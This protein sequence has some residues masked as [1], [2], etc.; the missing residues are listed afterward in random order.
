M[1][2]SQLTLNMKPVFLVI[3]FMLSFLSIDGRG[4]SVDDSFSNGFISLYK[5]SEVIDFFDNNTDLLYNSETLWV[6]QFYSHWCGH[7][8]RFAP[9]YREL[10]ESISAWS[11][12]V[13]FAA[14]NC[15]DQSC[16]KYQVQGTPTIRIF[17][18]HTAPNRLDS[19]F[20]GFNL[21][22]KSDRDYFLDIL[23]YNLAVV[24]GKG[25]KLP[26]HLNTIR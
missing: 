4:L 5:D 3:L 17:Y 8:Q 22:V 19:T 23:L 14:M 1:G 12:M 26:V 11:P 18:P 21:P 16:D 2:S 25:V 13:K 6:V 20:Y 15:A 9:F 10:A 7:C 24:A